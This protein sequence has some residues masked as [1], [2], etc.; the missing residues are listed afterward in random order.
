MTLLPRRALIAVAT[1]LDV[2]LHARPAPVS[3]KILAARH[4]L[5]PRHL[6]SILNALVRAGILKGVRGPRGGYELARERR[7]ITVAEIVRAAGQDRS[8][9]P[10][11]E[12]SPLLA[13][14]IAPAIDRAAQAFLRE[15]DA[16]TLEAL[17]AEALARGLPEAG[18]DPDFTI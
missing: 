16:I 1:V 3:A 9:E 12:V 18:G 17:C 8:E 2:A 4:Q 5:G 7:R 13:A 10:G 15:L 11:E 14:V 6:E